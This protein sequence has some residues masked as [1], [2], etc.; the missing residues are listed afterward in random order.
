MKTLL[1][2]LLSVFM[3]LSCNKHQSKI[4]GEWEVQED[5]KSQG[6]FIFKEDGTFISIDENGK[7]NDLGL[8]NGNT[9]VNMSYEYNASKE[10]DWLDLIYLGSEKKDKKDAIR[11]KCIA[12][13]LSDNTIRV[14]SNTKGD[15]DILE[16]P[17]SFD[18][19]ENI[20]LKRK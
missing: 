20:I 11:I 17:A 19:S 8:D 9:T 7:I 15:G 1:F 12:E 4:V 2:S 18:K 3:L 14:G 6:T 13:F 5:G 16:R 10:P